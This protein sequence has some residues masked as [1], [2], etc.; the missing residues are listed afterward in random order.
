VFAPIQTFGSMLPVP[1]EAFALK[2][3]NRLRIDESFGPLR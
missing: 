3:A 1:Y 2:A